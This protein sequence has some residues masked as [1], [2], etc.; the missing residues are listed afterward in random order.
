MLSCSFPHRLCPLLDSTANT[1]QPW[2]HIHTMKLNKD[3]TDQPGQTNLNTWKNPPAYKALLPTSFCSLAISKFIFWLTF[4]MDGVAS[5]RASRVSG[6]FWCY[7]RQRAGHP[8]WS[9]STGTMQKTALKCFPRWDDGDFATW[10]E[11]IICVCFLCV[12]WKC[13]AF[14][15]SPRFPTGEE[16]TVHCSVRFYWG[17]TAPAPRP[18]VFPR[19]FLTSGNMFKHHGNYLW[20]AIFLIS[21]CRF[22]CCFFFFSVKGHSEISYLS[23]LPFDDAFVFFSLS[24]FL[25]KLFPAPQGVAACYHSS[26]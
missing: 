14:F 6:L 7:C 13:S 4:S 18:K 26:V 9:A 2:S 1:L 17:L 12:K 24:V 20:R 8:A 19:V 25:T 23:V 5:T 10:W 11:Q 3:V 16:H 15:R 22:C 21:V